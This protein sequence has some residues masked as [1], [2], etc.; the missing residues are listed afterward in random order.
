MRRWNFAFQK[1]FA[2]AR[3]QTAGRVRRQDAEQCAPG[4]HPD[5]RLLQH[6]DKQIALMELPYN[7]GGERPVGLEIR[8]E[9]DAADLNARDP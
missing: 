3:W 5:K 9:Q 2:E 4:W 1:G 7:E 8:A 6:P